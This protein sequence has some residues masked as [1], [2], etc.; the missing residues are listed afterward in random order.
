MPDSDLLSQLTAF[1]SVVLIDV[2]LAGDNAVVVGTAAS[3]LP[4][5]QQRHVIMVGSALALVAR[6]AFALIATKLLA[7]IGLTL[8]GGL[9]LLWVAWKIWRE[10]RRGH[11]A[12]DGHAAGGKPKSFGAAVVQVAVADISMSLDNV[13]AIAGAAHDHPWI[14][15]FGLVLSIGLMAVAA[16]I[17]A[18]MIDRYRWIA[19]VGLFIVLAVA[20]KMIWEGGHEVANAVAAAG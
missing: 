11:V 13:L 5:K 4:P 2:V 8:A 12:A 20:C 9:L 10:I 1:V 19:Y 3:G 16:G 17:I 7:I 14:M 18:R 15:V 6:V